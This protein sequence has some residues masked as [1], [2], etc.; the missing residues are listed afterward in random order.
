MSDLEILLERYAYQKLYVIKMKVAFKK[1]KE[2]MKALHG[3]SDDWADFEKKLD[4]AKS[5][6]MFE[7]NVRL[8]RIEHEI[9]KLIYEDKNQGVTLNL[10]VD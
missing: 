7:Q 4:Y 8:R 3:D 5:S 1:R 9:T 10:R 2:S 6:S